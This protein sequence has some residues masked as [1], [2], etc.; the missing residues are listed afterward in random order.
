MLI[1]RR[2][3]IS[4]KTRTL[5]LPVTEWQMHDWRSGTV[6]QDAFPGLNT[7]QREFIITGSTEEEWKELF[8]DEE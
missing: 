3:P 8:G 2:S 1:T 7:W 6:A 4:G 5:D